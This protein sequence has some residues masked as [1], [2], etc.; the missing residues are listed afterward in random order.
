MPSPATTPALARNE[1]IWLLF[2]ITGSIAFSYIFACAVPLAA[3]AAAAALTVPKREAFLFILCVWLAN[4]LVGYAL[5]DYPQTADSVLWGGVMALAGLTAAVAA[6]ATA[7]RLPASL[8]ELAR[9]GAVFA[10]SFIAYELVLL[11]GAFTPLGGLDDFAPAIIGR[12]LSID[13]LALALVYG[14]QKLA[15]ATGFLRARASLA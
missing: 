4:Q 7:R 15:F 2:L 1:K 6:F 8:P 13:M 10:A 5:L 3:L 9:Y 12:V 11:A 14:L